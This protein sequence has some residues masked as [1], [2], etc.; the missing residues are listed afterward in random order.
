MEVEVVLREVREDE[1]R[2]PRTV[3]AVQHARMRGCFHRAAAI[4]CIKHLAKRPLEVDR[5]GGRQ[6][7]AASL[8]TDATL[9]RAEEPRSAPGGGEHR[10]E[11]KR[12]RCLA[13]RPRDPRN[14]ELARR[15]AEECVC[16]ET[17][18]DAGI[19][20]DE[21]G[22]RKLERTLD[23]E[24]NGPS[25]DRLAGEHVAVAITPGD[26]EEERPRPRIA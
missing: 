11:E 23:N 13:V 9:D 15:T 21:L 16:G 18:R 1:N 4:A 25:I 12:R 3:E 10:E 22:G 8:T 24:R 20:D 5:F 19:G 17:H 14:R 7:Y 26:A 2:E 6:R